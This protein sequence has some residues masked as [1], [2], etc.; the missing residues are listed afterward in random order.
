MPPLIDL[1]EES[2]RLAYG[3]LEAGAAT[4]KSGNAILKEL[5]DAGLSIRR[6]TGLDIIAVLRDKADIT[7]FVRSFPSNTPIPDSV[8]SEAPTVLGKRYTYRV[9]II[10]AAP[11]SPKYI[12][13]AS[14]TA[15]TQ[16][17]IFDAAESNLFGDSVP[18][19]LV[20]SD[21]SPE[22]QIDRGFRR[23]S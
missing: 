10:N 18:S 15:L 8:L 4:A 2:A 19:N 1:L 6:Q 23:V 9:R 12:N 20:P 21:F 3:F 14:Q 22:F 16:D 17:E 7:R 11:G 13:V 5:A